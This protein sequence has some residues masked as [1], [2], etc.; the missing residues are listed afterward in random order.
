[1]STSP[2]SFPSTQTTVPSNPATNSPDPSGLANEETFLQLLVA[3]IKNQDPTQ[4]TDGTQFLTQL[5]QFSSLE[6][7]IGIKG[8]LDTATKTQT[9][10]NAATQQAAG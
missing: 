9:T 8:D 2:V 4:P 1:M 3:Q 5:A 7:L 10:Q 6:Q